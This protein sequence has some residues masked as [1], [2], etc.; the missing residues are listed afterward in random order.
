MVT[1]PNLENFETKIEKLFGD[2]NQWFQVNKLTL[3]YNKT[4]YCTC[5][6]QT[7]IARIII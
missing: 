7:K 5:N 4:H 1:S 3:N 6:V 2:I